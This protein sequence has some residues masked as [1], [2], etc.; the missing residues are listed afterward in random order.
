MFTRIELIREEQRLTREAL[1]AKAGVSRG[2]LYGIERQG[3]Q[4]R[5]A[6]V[7][8]LAH[9]LDCAPEDLV[10]DDGAPCKAPRVTASTAAAGPAPDAISAA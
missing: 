5:R 3:R 2:A 1:A 6:T 8:V 4:P 9:A 7:Y 10:Q